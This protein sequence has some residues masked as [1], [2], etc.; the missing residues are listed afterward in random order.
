MP[1]TASN[2][3][4]PSYQ[5]IDHFDRAISTHKQ[6]HDFDVINSEYKT[7]IQ[8]VY[9]FAELKTLS[10]VP[11]NPSMTKEEF[12]NSIK[13]TSL[14]L[15]SGGTFVLDYHISFLCELGMLHKT[16]E[17]FIITIP[18]YL[19]NQILAH[20]Q[21]YHESYLHLK[22]INTTI[23]S[24]IK[25]NVTYGEL[26]NN[27]RIEYNE[28]YHTQFLHICQEQNVKCENPQ[29][30]QKINLRFS[31]CTK[32][33]FIESDKIDAITNITLC[34]NTHERF[35]YN[36]TIFQTLSHRISDNLVYI[37]FTNERNYNTN[38]MESYIGS[39]NFSRID[40]TMLE[41][42][43]DGITDMFNMKM[44]A[45][46]FN[47]FRTTH[48]M[49]GFGYHTYNP[50]A[51]P[52]KFYNSWQKH[53]KSVIVYNKLSSIIICPISYDNIDEFYMKCSQCNNCFDYDCI[54]KWTKSKNTCPLCRNK[55]DS[56]TK[57]VNKDDPNS[58]P[59]DVGL[60]STSNNVIC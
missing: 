23:F 39:T 18:D 3:D 7:R 27:D 9:D 15:T 53:K 33:F 50:N 51:V 6:E 56:Y 37:S 17:N 57:Y 32:G 40:S 58:N 20:F 60:E 22:N 4:I 5:L 21:L 8:T 25:A 2:E 31:H 10:F 16:D 59:S 30:P 11:S 43:F 12:I 19:R 1:Q 55:W 48:G 13:D 46:H 52:Q 42:T 28:K 44:Y 54:I 45:I 35:S 49:C 34:L 41:I 29:H 26:S 47:L 14:V 36:K 38:S 24:N